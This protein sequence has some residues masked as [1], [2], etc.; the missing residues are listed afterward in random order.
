MLLPSEV[1]APL[2]PA[3]APGLPATM[4]FLSVMLVP[5]LKLPIPPKL[6]P[7]DPV[8]SVTVQFTRLTVA[9]PVCAVVSMPP[10]VPPPGAELPLMVQL[11][12]VVV[13]A[14]PF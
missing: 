2:P 13:V 3:C 9:A 8:L 6:P 1:I 4:V 7:P 5:A 10:A 11:V 12:S 14:E